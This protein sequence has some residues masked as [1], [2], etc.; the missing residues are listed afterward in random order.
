MLSPLPYVSSFTAPEE[1][2]IFDQDSDGG[3][4]KSFHSGLGEGSHMNHQTVLCSLNSY[5]ILMTENSLM[6]QEWNG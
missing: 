3:W 5:D 4:A 6:F 2:E 1:F